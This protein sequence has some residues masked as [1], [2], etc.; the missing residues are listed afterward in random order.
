M[1]EL[2]N[3]K[4]VPLHNQ[5]EL[6]LYSHQLNE[7]ERVDLKPDVLVTTVPGLPNQKIIGAL[8]SVRYIAQA[9]NILDSVF[10]NSSTHR[11]MNIAVTIGWND[12]TKSYFWPS[13]GQP[14]TLSLAKSWKLIDKADCSK[15]SLD[16]NEFGVIPDLNYPLFLSPDYT[17]LAPRYGSENL[18]AFWASILWHEWQH[19]LQTRYQLPAL[20]AWSEIQA[21]SQ[22]GRFLLQLIQ[23][24][25]IKHNAEGIILNNLRKF[26]QTIYD[27]R[28][29]ILD[30]EHPD[31]HGS[32]LKDQDLHDEDF[33]FGY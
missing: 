13:N 14:I 25:N 4:F 6:L 1:S 31:L 20:S 3:R 8:D 18:T 24:G 26:S 9:F 27:F 2:S 10:P 32:P 33:M 16:L 5:G 12:E 17:S 19:V 21:L 7:E 23:S 22:Q 30:N 29:G 28:N 11:E 15:Y